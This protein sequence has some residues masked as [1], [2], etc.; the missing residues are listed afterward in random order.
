MVIVETESDLSLLLTKLRTEDFVMDIVLTDTKKHPLNNDVSIILLH[1][2]L[3]K[4]NWCFPLLHSECAAPIDRRTAWY[5]RWVES[6]RLSVSKKYVLDKKACIEVLGEDFQLL[7]YNVFKYLDDGKS[8]DFRDLTTNAEQFIN[9]NFGQLEGLNQSIPIY[10]HATRFNEKLT[11]FTTAEITED[12][13]FD[14]INNIAIPRFAQL[15]SIGL[16]V[17]ESL[18]IDS[19]GPEHGQH[20]KDGKVYSQYNL[21]TSTGRPSNRFGG[22]NYAAVNK[23]DGSR[24]PFV[25]RFGNDGMLVMID[26][27]AFHPR[28][29]ANLA[30]YH[31]P[32]EENPYEYLARFFFKKER[33]SPPEIASTKGMCFQQFYGGIR[34]E[35]A[36]IPY[37]RAAQTY[38]NHRWN[39]FVDNEYVETPIYYRRI[40]PC[41]IEDPSPNKL[42]NYIL[43]AFETEISVVTL[44]RTLDYLADKP[45]KPILYTYDSIL[46]DIHRID[47]M[48][49]VK[50]L[51]DIMVDGKYP[52]K[53]YVGKN[54]DEMAKIII[55]D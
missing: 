54:Y 5:Q 30:N 52:V 21:Y 29:I 14:F 33:P 13:S 7:D 38:I 4:T 9:F 19:Y 55:P 53:V 51:R 37:F 27:S 3:D 31:I 24:K 6:M 15:E 48:P 43:Q 46:Y 1:F 42:F 16:A 32:M 44:G 17:D 10:K 36:H 26:Y 20:I 11:K 23:S 39:F 28:L 34:G 35:Y 22:V 18:F 8:E 12:K 47:G 50:K 45:S 41:H 2:L 49:T 40:K 25:S